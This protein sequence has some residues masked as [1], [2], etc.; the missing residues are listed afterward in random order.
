M[1][2]L[3]MDQLNDGDGADSR[4]DSEDDERPAAAAQ[5]SPPSSDGE[6]GDESDDEPEP[7]TRERISGLMHAAAFGGGDQPAASDTRSEVSVSSSKRRKTASKQAFPCKGVVCV[8]CS[9]PQRI[10][11]VNKFVQQN[12]SC[13]TQDALFKMAALVYKREVCEP[14]VREGVD[15][16]PWSWKQVRLHYSLHCTSNEIQRHAIVRQL[17]GLR[18]QLESHLLRVDDDAKEVDRATAEL[19]LKTVAA[20]SK[21]RVLMD[22][23]AGKKAR[24]D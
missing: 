12:V 22:A 1:A 20:E 3:E 14:A 23:G 10:Q 24:G 2:S 15:V 9:L 13:M 11:P 8:G 4:I 16:P 21:E 17:Q 6:A 5:G 18:S 7:G 19:L